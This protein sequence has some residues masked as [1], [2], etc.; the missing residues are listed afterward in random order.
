MVD[1]YGRAGQIALALTF[2]EVMP[3]GNCLLVWT[4]LL[5][6]CK[7]WANLNLG[8]LAFEHAIELDEE[9]ATAYIC[10]SNIYGLFAL[11]Q[12]YDND[13]MET[14]KSFSYKIT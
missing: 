3:V 14:S 13:N 9:N 7:K 8:R 1:L 10:M 12:L 2:I 5:G 4:A 6:T 11:S